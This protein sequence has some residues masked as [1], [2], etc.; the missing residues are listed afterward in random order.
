[1]VCKKHGAKVA[2]LTDLPSGMPDNLFRDAVPDIIKMFDLYVSS[3]TCGYRKPNRAGLEYIAK[4]FDIDVKDILFV[5]D[6]DKD[7]QTA[8]NAGCDFMHID[9]FRKFEASDKEK[10]CL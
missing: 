6:E 5:G 10:I 8:E 1:M 2:C 3:Q 9:E 7:R 4:N